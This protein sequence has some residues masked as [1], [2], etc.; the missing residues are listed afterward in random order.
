MACS[1]AQKKNGAP[2]RQSPLGRSET[3][4]SRNAPTAGATTAMRLF[5]P[6][7]A[8]SAWPW[9]LGSA[10]L[11]RQRLGQHEPAVQQV[12]QREAARGEERQAQVDRAEQPAHHRPEDESQAE[13]RP[14]HAEALGA[15]LGRRDVGDVGVGH[16]NVG[17]H[18]AAH[19]ANDDQHPQ[20]GGHRGEQEA[21]GEAAEA[22][23]QNRAAAIPV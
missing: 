1:V 8:P 12:E 6:P 14:Q 2:M 11:E 13:H 17:L 7:T 16:G 10:A 19:Q 5:R 23:Q 4:V 3:T 15:I 21:G 9:L 18:R 20:R 22:D